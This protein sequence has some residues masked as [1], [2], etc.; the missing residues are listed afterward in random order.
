[1]SLACESVGIDVRDACNRNLAAAS[2]GLLDAVVFRDQN[3][4]IPALAQHELS[5]LA[6]SAA[7]FEG[8]AFLRIHSV[9]FRV[10]KCSHHG[11][12]FPHI[13]SRRAATLPSPEGNY[14]L[15]TEL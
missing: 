5:L 14:N 15:D 1:M 10:R 2:S 12:T 9:V 11:S 6:S 4:A 8:P 3:Q 7:S 13:T